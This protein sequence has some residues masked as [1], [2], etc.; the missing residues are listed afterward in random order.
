MP[1]N[2]LVIISDASGTSLYNEFLDDQFTSCD[3]TD[4]NNKIGLWK[5]DDLREYL[6][7][8]IEVKVQTDKILEQIS[9]IILKEKENY[10][11]KENI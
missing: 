5:Y 2:L 7:K 11:K 10:G 3:F 6:E 8:L 1:D 4:S 9:E